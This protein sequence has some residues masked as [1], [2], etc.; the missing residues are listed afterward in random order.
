M[1]VRIVKCMAHHTEA[2]PTMR[3]RMLTL[4]LILLLVAACSPNSIEPKSA[5]RSA[6]VDG[7][8]SAAIT[9]SSTV[10]NINVTPLTGDNL[11]DA[12]VEYLGELKFDVTGTTAR[13]INFVDELTT[14]SYSGREINWN[15]QLN[16]AVPLTLE[17][18]SSSGNFDLNLRDFM[19][20]G[21]EIHGSSG[22]MELALPAS[23]APYPVEI[24]SSS[25]NL[26][27]AVDVGGQ[28]SFQS[29]S[30]SSGNTTITA[31]A[32]SVVSADVMTSSGAITFV[33]MS[34]AS[35]DAELSS[36]SG[37]IVIDVPDDAAV[38]LDVRSQTSGNV[39]IPANY[40]HTGNGDKTGVWQTDG[41]DDAEVQI[42]VVITTLSSGN[43]EVR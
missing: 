13:T 21:L 19:L 37:N 34:G 4:L 1:R 14:Y 23:D 35:L 5:Q 24:T 7:A 39:T 28:V 32:G 22:N 36:S 10:S 9:L 41:Y 31:E 18:T 3:N 38:R 43:I 16:P 29:I 26:T 6:P 30:G 40:T 33:V 12:S 20:A 17:V 11:I 2:T 25:G 42:D 27:A 15:V 8:E